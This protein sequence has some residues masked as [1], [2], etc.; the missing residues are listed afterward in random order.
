MFSQLKDIFVSESVPI[1]SAID[2]IHE[3]ALGVV[4]V[5]DNNGR[6]KGTVTDG[7][8]RRAI[9][10]NVDLSSPVKDIM[11][12]S[13]TSA[14]DRLPEFELKKIMLNKG[15]MALPILDEQGAVIDIIHI[16]KF[17]RGLRQAGRLAHGSSEQIK[18]VLIIGGS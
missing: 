12:Q 5:T 17:P 15:I 9:L 11:N 6:L 7:D 3:C 14:K 2:R 8:V 13:P 1:K 4:L 10:K 16:T 18:R